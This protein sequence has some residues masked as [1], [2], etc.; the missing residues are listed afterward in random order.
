MRPYVAQFLCSP[1]GYIRAGEHVCAL[2]IASKYPPPYSLATP[3]KAVAWPWTRL[4]LRP[5]QRCFHLITAKI[6]SDS[7]EKRKGFDGKSV[8]KKPIG[9]K[10]MNLCGMYW[11]PPTHNDPLVKGPQPR[12]VTRKQYKHL[13]G[14]RNEHGDDG[15]MS[16]TYNA[17][18]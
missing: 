3:Q 11:W 6:R 12:I 18:N 10:L 17:G 4:L 8:Y 5:R 13:M 14:M 15:E 9:E 2:R 16:V 1:D 7:I